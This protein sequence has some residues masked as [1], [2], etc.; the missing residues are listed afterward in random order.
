MHSVHAKKNNKVYISAI[1]E[2]SKLE[3]QTK[4]C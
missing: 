3:D 1:V 4:K 2:C